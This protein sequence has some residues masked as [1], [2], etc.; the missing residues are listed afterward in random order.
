MKDLVIATFNVENLDDIDPNLWAV[1]TKVLRRMLER[2]GAHV[3]LLQEVHSLNALDDLRKGTSYEHYN[4]AHTVS[5]SSGQPYRYRNLVILSEKAIVETKQYRN[6]LVDAPRWRKI[7]SVPSETEAKRLSWERPI[8]HSK[9]RLS[10]SK[11]LHVINLHLKSMN[12]TNVKGQRHED[13]YWLWFS[14]QGWAEGYY[15]SD[16]KRVGQA[17]ET[18][19]LIDQIFAQDGEDALIVV[20]GDLNAEVGSVPFRAI[21]G[22]VEDTQN[23]VLRTGVLVP[24]EFNVPEDSR[25]SLFHHGK[26]NMLDHL[27]VSQALIPYWID[28]AVFNETLHDESLAF[29]TDLKFPESDHAPIVSRF[30]VPW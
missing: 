17:L 13:K 11:T 21:V 27:I 10:G 20:G 12:P 8:L 29:A 22:S 14:H 4:R 19:V 6:D 28:T 25:Y 30:K 26:G 18:R 3:L 2:I 5:P 1:R 9:V 7:T 23:E 15:I 16:V 24:C